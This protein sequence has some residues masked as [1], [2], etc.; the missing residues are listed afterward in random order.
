[1]GYQE[2]GRRIKALREDLD[3]TQADLAARVGIKQNKLSG[4]ETGK[5][6]VHVDELQGFAAALETTVSF[7]VSG[8][9][10]EHET[11]I[12]DL[13]LSDQAI[14]KLMISA[15]KDQRIQ[16][17][18]DILV[19]DP[20]ILPFLY[21]YFT[22]PVFDHLLWVH[23]GIKKIPLEYVRGIDQADLERIIRLRVSDDLKRIRD[24]IQSKKSPEEREFD[25]L[26]DEYQ[27]KFGK[28]YVFRMEKDCPSW[29]KTL[30]DIR[31]RIAE[32]DPQ[33]FV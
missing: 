28:P 11:V 23:H 27:A 1:M 9:D 20:D 33:R 30:S 17:A 4:I 10:P 18:V 16:K 24:G 7:L 25:V 6:A 3:L 12:R 2:I 21:H 26:N 13:K 22:D 5:Q 29:K 15:E 14:R 19:C 32:N 31:K 8:C